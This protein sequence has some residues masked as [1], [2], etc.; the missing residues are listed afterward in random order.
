MTRESLASLL[1]LVPNAVGALADLPALVAIGFADK[2]TAA[3]AA[4]ALST[5]ETPRTTL[6]L[7]LEDTE[8][9]H[10]VVSFE[11]E[12]ITSTEVLKALASS[13][14]VVGN[15]T[16]FADYD[17]YFRFSFGEGL[18]ARVAPLTPGVMASGSLPKAEAQKLFVI[19]HSYDQ[20][21]SAHAHGGLEQA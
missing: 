8:K 16:R 13:V 18:A 10:L 17:A 7:S 15:Q 3:R 20:Q 6:E 4:E 1:G 21:V 19:E 12:D 5:N 11:H 14:S 9:P 2:A